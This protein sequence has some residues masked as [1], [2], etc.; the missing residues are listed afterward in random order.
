MTASEVV[1]GFFLAL[2]EERW[3]DAVGFLSQ[4]F[5]AEHEKHVRHRF[6]VM[7]H[8]L[9]EGE[10]LPEDRN[11]LFRM[12]LRKADF[13]HEAARLLAEARREQPGHYFEVVGGVAPP[14][15]RVIG[16][17]PDGDG[18]AIVVYRRGGG[19]GTPRTLEAQ[20]EDGVWRVC[21]EGFAQEGLPGLAWRPPEGWTPPERPERGAG[22]T[23]QA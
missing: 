22:P 21:S 5:K 7:I 4:E 14:I 9:D 20:L 2:K 12:W 16:E 15:R 19:R 10:T 18:R 13:R 3:G 8:Y 11:A 23:S 17:V 1:E 6:R